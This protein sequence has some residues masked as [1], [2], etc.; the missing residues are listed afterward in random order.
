MLFH[1]LLARHRGGTHDPLSE[2]EID[3]LFLTAEGWTAGA[4]AIALGVSER[5]AN[6]HISNAI[7]KL[8]AANKAQAVAMALR[9]GLME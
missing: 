7:D 1:A 3:C 6:Y 2:R 4:I 9:R 5:T 8:G